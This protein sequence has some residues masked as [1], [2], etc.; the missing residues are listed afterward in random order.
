MSKPASYGKR[1]QATGY[2]AK[3]NSDAKFVH[4]KITRVS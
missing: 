4:A 1:K 2:G 3:K